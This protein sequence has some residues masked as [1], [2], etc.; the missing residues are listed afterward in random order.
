MSWNEYFYKFPR[1]KVYC[2]VAEAIN[3]HYNLTFNCMVEPD[4]DT[5]RT[6]LSSAAE[7]ACNGKHMYYVVSE[8]AYN[9]IKSKH[10]KHIDDANKCVRYPTA[11]AKK[12][13]REHIIPADYVRKYVES[14]RDPDVYGVVDI[15]LIKPIV[16]KLY[17]AIITREED[18]QLKKMGYNTQMPEGYDFEADVTNGLTRYE[19]AGI[20]IHKWE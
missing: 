2:L 19:A 17:I 14:K 15:E 9:M 4:K 11:L 8:A 16:D 20:K 6:T 3:P 18:Q 7:R 10:P 1:E 13:T 5:M 12:L